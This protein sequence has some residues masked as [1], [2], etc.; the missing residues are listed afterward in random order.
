MIT[1]DRVVTTRSART[2]AF[3]GTHIQTV[4]IGAMLLVVLVV[5]AATA[6]TFLSVENV[7]SVLRQNSP[8]L[9]V[10]VLMTFVITTGGIDLS[11]GSVL[12]LSGALLG[13]LISAGID[14]TLAFLA[15]L[16][17]GA[18]VGAV[19]GWFSHY[20]GI[21]SFIV[22]LAM[23]GIIRGTALRATD[24]YSIS[25]PKE[26]WVGFLGQG[27]IAGVPAQAVIAIV[28][29][30][31][32]WVVFTKTPFGQ[33]VTGLGSNRE[34]LRRAGVNVRLVGF[35]VFML[36][37]VAAALAGVLVAMRLGSGS[38]NQGVNFE[39]A[40]ITAVVLGG[41]NL[42]GGRG[43][44]LGTVL[45]VLTLGFIENG[46]QLAHVSP[47]YVQIVQGAI[48]LAAIL[49]NAKLFSRFTVAR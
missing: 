28:I 4:A 36:V 35:T 2:H 47:F 40:V 20:Q 26:S 22:T 39:L 41:T 29:A 42:F 44:V 49:A 23:L 3:L 16:L 43:T 14:P 11:V 17:L 1:N 10:A 19:N 45:G 15:V 8:A 9:I 6:D 31:V 12:A 27:R 33:Y 18:V 48:L 7:L 46:L 38:A 24:G 30:V 32:G 37:G 13:I 5:F 21:P 34:S 25:I